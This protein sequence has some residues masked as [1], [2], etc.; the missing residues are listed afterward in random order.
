MQELMKISI[1]EQKNRFIDKRDREWVN[2]TGESEKRGLSTGTTS[3]STFLTIGDTYVTRLLDAVLD[4][5]EKTLSSDTAPVMDEH[6]FLELTNDL[7]TLVKTEYNNIRDRA[8]MR[9]ELISR[10]ERTALNRDIDLLL[11]QKTSSIKQ[12]VNAIKERLNAQLPTTASCASK[13][14]GPAVMGGGRGALCVHSSQ[15]PK[16]DGVGEYQVLRDASAHSG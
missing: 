4:D 8:F 9:F 2:L 7:I 12:R 3:I 1:Q 14:T 16:S 15:D 13:P 6:Y 11:S 5:E 10:D